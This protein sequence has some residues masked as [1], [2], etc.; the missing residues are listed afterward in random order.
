LAVTAAVIV[1]AFN[2]ST[3]S[4][5]PLYAVGVFLAFTLSQAG[6]VVHWWRRRGTHWRRGIGL[7]GLGAVLSALVLLTAAVTKFTEG[8]WV[9]VVGIALLIL[10]W[11][12]IRRH[13]AVVRTT[14]ALHPLP[15][16]TTRRAITPAGRASARRSTPARRAAREE[17]ERQES[18]EEMEHLAVAPVARIDLASLRALAYAASLGMPVLGVHISPDEAEAERFREQWRTW[19]DHI[20]LEI[21]ESP[22]RAIVAPLAHYLNALHT[23][24]PDVTITVILPEIVV[25]KHWHTIL[26]AHTGARLRRALRPFAGLVVTTVPVHLKE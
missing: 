6:M 1:V 3:E 16:R 24:R 23:T 13:Y 19:G 11:V 5:V 12:R 25:K 20:P 26:H 15:A 9:V 21:I 8:A 2:G 10:L 4:L 14:L 22:Y 17:E 18:P 7:N